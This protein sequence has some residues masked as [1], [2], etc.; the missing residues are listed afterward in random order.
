MIDFDAV[1]KLQ[2]PIRTP[3]YVVVNNSQ[4]LFVPSRINL[5]GVEQ[6]AGYMLDGADGILGTPVFLHSKMQIRQLGTLDEYLQDEFAQTC[7]PRVLKY[8]RPDD[9]VLPVI[10]VIECLRS[11]NDLDVQGLVNAVLERRSALIAQS[12]LDSSE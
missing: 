4:I 1:F 5:L 8:F 11:D 12:R 9:G 2:E 10:C 7:L 6:Y 3:G